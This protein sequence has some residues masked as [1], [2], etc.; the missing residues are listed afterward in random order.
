MKKLIA[1]VAIAAFISS[2]NSGTSTNSESA[3]DSS[4]ADKKMSC[5]LYEFYVFFDD[6]DCGRRNYDNERWEN[7]GYEWR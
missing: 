4:M 6:V 7:D 2:C 5:R 3:S 1:I